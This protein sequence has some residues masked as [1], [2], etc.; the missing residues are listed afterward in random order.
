MERNS[1]G[2]A[3]VIDEK[4]ISARLSEENGIKDNCD[5]NYQNRG[6]A[7]ADRREAK[8]RSASRKPKRFRV[9]PAVAPKAQQARECHNNV[10]KQYRARLKLRFEKLL[11]VLQASRREDERPRE[12][13]SLETNYCFSRGD[14]LDAAR[15]RISALEEE[16]KRLSCKIQELSQ[17]WMVG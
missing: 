15:Q 3:S 5:D 9:K 6:G 11:T 10:E 13:K 8:L 4:T 2:A 7:P 1:A 17:A 16:N 12:A 14:I